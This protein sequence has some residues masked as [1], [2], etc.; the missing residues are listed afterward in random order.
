MGALGGAVYFF[1]FLSSR[2]QPIAVFAVLGLL[3]VA[4]DA[5]ASRSLR[6]RNEPSVSV[7]PRGATRVFLRAVGVFGLAFSTALAV[8]VVLFLGLVAP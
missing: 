4:L 8:T 3:A 7:A 6:R 2:A 5:L 1:A